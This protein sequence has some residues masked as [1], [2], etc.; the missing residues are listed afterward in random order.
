MF[1]KIAQLSKSHSSYSIFFLILCKKVHSSCSDYNHQKR[2][3]SIAAK[4]AEKIEW[5]LR[6]FHEIFLKFS[7]NFFFVNLHMVVFCCFLEAGSHIPK[8][9]LLF[10]KMI[11]N[12]TIYIYNNMM[13]YMVLRTIV[14][15]LVGGKFGFFMN[16]FSL[17][18]C[19]RKRS[20]I[21][22]ITICF[23]VSMPSRSIKNVLLF[24][25]FGILEDYKINSSIIV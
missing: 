11:C 3:R 13:A 12:I 14:F 2:L 6:N 21:F 22:A 10:L 17:L 1:Q 9:C 16:F 25:N 23:F 5:W 15:C 20:L 4:A 8:K 18:F 19:H 7:R 24:Q